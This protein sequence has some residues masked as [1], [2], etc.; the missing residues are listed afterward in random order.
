MTA[1]SDMSVPTA[2]LAGMSQ[3]RLPDLGRL[4]GLVTTAELVEAGVTGARIRT[5][6]R[7]GVLVSLCRGVYAQAVP[8]ARLA[9]SQRG[10]RAL[11]LAAAVALV[12][13]QS[14]GSHQ[15][16]AILHK[17]ALLERPHADIVAV[18][19]P[20]EVAG[21][22]RPRSGI[23]LH[24]AALPRSQVTVR[25]G[26]PVTS[27]ARTVIDLAR[28]VP[29]RSG[30][31]VAD[32]ALHGKQASKDELRA[33]LTTCARWPGIERARHVVD[34]SDAR[35]ESPFE[36]IARVAFRDG[37]L[38]PPD[39]QVWVGGDG[40]VIGRADFLWP[41]HATIAEA[42]GAIKYADPDRARLQLQRDAELREAGFEV[43]HFSWR[44]LTNA[45]GQVIQSIRA[46]FR[47]AAALRSA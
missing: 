4:A 32:S 37:G 25:G 1:T 13:P 14:V 3:S 45:P 22:R 9:A 6:V 39:L 15:D 40:R 47:R 43:V 34:F 8:A 28:S 46:A 10:E 7:H 30:V 21:S 31:V 35:S 20:P 41:A 36:S 27:V 24:I 44:E 18:S 11:R 19:R 5:L 26:V 42:D 12:G 16:A 23:Q 17:L 2:I 38:P 33:V 29:F